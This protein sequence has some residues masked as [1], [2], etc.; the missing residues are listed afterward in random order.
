MTGSVDPAT[1]KEV[2]KIELGA[3]LTGMIA[4]SGNLV[5][6]TDFAGHLHAFVAE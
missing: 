2:Q 5:Y 1:G 6:T 4:V 3:P